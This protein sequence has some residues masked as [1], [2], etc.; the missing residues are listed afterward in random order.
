MNQIRVI[1][2]SL[3]NGTDKR[4]IEFAEMRISKSAT[5]HIRGA[6]VINED[7]YKEL[8]GFLIYV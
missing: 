8:R 4:K 1:I 2:A 7:T 3:V 6:Q 5:C